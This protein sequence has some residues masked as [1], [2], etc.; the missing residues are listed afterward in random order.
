M[1]TNERLMLRPNEAAEAIG[2]SRSKAYELIAA[3]QIP[4][5]KVGGC[6][7]VPVAALQAWINSQL[8][9]TAWTANAVRGGTRDGVLLMAGFNTMNNPRLPENTPPDKPGAVTE[10]RR[11]ADA[12][13][14]L[15]Q[16]YDERAAVELNARFPFG[17]PT[18]R[19]RRGA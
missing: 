4:S 19:W 10:L 15:L 5:V 14:R 1:N 17:R 12:L 3:G 16:L 13:E 6:V 2:V 7:R 9:Q 11:I 18:D 8:Q